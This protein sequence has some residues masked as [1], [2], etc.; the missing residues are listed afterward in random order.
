MRIGWVPALLLGL[1]RV[2]L[3]LHLPNMELPLYKAVLFLIIFISWNRI[4][5]LGFTR[6]PGSP[7]A[8]YLGGTMDCTVPHWTFGRFLHEINFPSWYPEMFYR[9]TK[10]G[11]RSVFC[12]KGTC[13]KFA[14]QGCVAAAVWR[15]DCNLQEEPLELIPFVKS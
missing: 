4:S 5:V 11:V 12:R 6:C 15:S 8:N 10:D 14:R 1:V 13:F 7:E 9:F 2:V 3:K